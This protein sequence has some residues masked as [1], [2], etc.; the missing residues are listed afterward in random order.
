MVCCYEYPFPIKFPVA[1][2][3]AFSNISHEL[4]KEINFKCPSFPLFM[5]LFLF[6]HTPTS[7]NSVAS[8]SVESLTS[9]TVLITEFQE[10]KEKTFCIA[11]LFLS[12]IIRICLFQ[13]FPLFFRNRFDVINATALPISRIM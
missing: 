2:P 8:S 11:H 6:L 1:F 9:L 12:S 5:L 3:V 10:G 13:F 4:L 7:L